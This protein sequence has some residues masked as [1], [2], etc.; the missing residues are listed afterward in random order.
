MALSKIN[1]KD[2]N[3]SKKTLTN[4]DLGLQRKLCKQYLTTFDKVKITGISLI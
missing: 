3:L 2:P 4:S 1:K